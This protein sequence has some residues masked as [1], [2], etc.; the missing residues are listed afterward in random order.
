MSNDII[1]I[2]KLAN[3]YQV[4]RDAADKQEY[5]TLSVKELRE[6]L[7]EARKDVDNPANFTD[8]VSTFQQ[9]LFLAHEMNIAARIIERI[10]MVSINIQ[11]SGN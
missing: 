1:D 2:I 3:A 9:M 4:M 11:E 7:I 10:N 8:E 5:S 6:K